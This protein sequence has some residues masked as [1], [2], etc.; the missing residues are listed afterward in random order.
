MPPMPFPMP[1]LFITAVKDICAINTS[2]KL[3][4]ILFREV[5]CRYFGFTTPLFST[6]ITDMS[7]YDVLNLFPADHAYFNLFFF[8]RSSPVM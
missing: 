1:P 4:N 6:T 3:P 2:E 8:P 7:L 5:Y